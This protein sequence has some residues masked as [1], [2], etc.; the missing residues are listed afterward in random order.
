MG[1]DEINR[2]NEVK[3]VAL[4]LALGLTLWAGRRIDKQGPEV[5]AAILTVASLAIMAMAWLK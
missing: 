5:G 3:T 1:F 4:I 2:I